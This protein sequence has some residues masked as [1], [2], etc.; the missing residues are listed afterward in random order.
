MRHSVADGKHGNAGDAPPGR[1][2]PEVAVTRRRVL[3]TSH[4]AGGTVPPMLA[5]AE[6]FMARG[7]VVVVLSQPSVRARAEAAGCAFLPFTDLPNYAPRRA[8]EDQLDLSLRAITAQAIGDDV[9]AAAKEH[10]S[11]L[12]VVDANLAGALAAAEQLDRPSAVLLHSMY[13]TFVTSWFADYWSFLEPAI[14]ETRDA[15]GLA[16]ARDWPGVFAG[17]DR[18]LAVVPRAFDA[19]VAD[20]PRTLRHFGFLVPNARAAHTAADFGAGKEPTVLVGLSTTYQRQ[21]ELLEVI[22]DALGGLP[23]RALVTTAG[24]IDDGALPHPANVTIT[25]YVPHA[26]VLD[27][28]AVMVTHGGLGSIASALSFGVPLVCTPVSRDQFVNAERVAAVGAGIALAESPTAA[29]VAT[30]IKQVLSK[31]RFRAGAQAMADASRAAGGATAAVA[32]LDAL[33]D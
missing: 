13:T 8:I 21:E 27:H 29:Q 31:P 12:L 33:L 16:P 24:Q 3:F 15:F 32:E 2:A 26:A 4:D 11:D 17:H 18:L 19:P 5:L 14:N 1:S 23:V 25:D 9:I 10:A 6:A 28:T 30:A 22:L 20:T 7:D